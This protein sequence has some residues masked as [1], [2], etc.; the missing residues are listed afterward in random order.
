MKVL[1]IRGKNLASLE[2]EFEIDFRN[3]P[4][5]SAGIFAITG[6]TGAGK[7]TLLDALCLA[8]YDMTP[9]MS[10]AREN[11]VLVSDVMDKSLSQ[12]DTRSIL[13]RGTVDGYAE[14]DFKALDGCEY[15][16]RWMV[17]RSRGQIAG[18]L[19]KVEMRLNNLTTG[20]E[21]GGTKTELLNQIV[22]L[23]GLSFEQFSRSVL[24]AQGDFA[25]F[26]KAKQSEKAEILEKLTGTE[27][28][29]YISA[30]IYEHWKQA[31]EE[32]EYVKQ[33]LQ[34]I[35]ILS[36]EELDKISN[37]KIELENRLYEK[38][39]IIEK[40]K[41]CLKWMDDKKKLEELLCQAKEQLLQ[42]EQ[43]YANAASRI[44]YWKQWELV[45]SI[46]EVYRQ[47]QNAVQ[48]LDVYKK[49]LLQVEEDREKVKILLQ[50]KQKDREKA[51]E[52]LSTY[53]KYVT[54]IQPQIEKAHHLD[55]YIQEQEKQIKDYVNR[56]QQVYTNLKRLETDLNDAVQKLNNTK[57]K[58]KEN[59]DWLFHYSAYESL[60]PRVDLVSDLTKLIHSA[61]AFKISNEKLLDENKKI[62]VNESE[63]LELLKKEA[64]HLQTLLP[65]EV[66]TL[67]QG[68]QEGEACPVCGSVHH[69]YAGM[70]HMQSLH[71]EQ[72]KK[73]KEQNAYSLNLLNDSI[74][75]HTLE[76]SR[77]QVLI[78]TY[79][80]QI[81]ENKQKLS[82][83]V[84][85]LPDWEK[86]LE[87]GKLGKYI[88]EFVR[89]WNEHKLRENELTESE[90]LLQTKID[91]FHAEIEN[92]KAEE[93]NILSSYNEMSEQLQSRK[94]DRLTLFEG[95]QIAEVVNE[96]NHKQQQLEQ[97]ARR[98]QEE[99]QSYT[100]Q[101]NSYIGKKEQLEKEYMRY[102]TILS[103]ASQE[104]S[105]WLDLH[106]EIKDKDFLRE[107]F[108]KD[109]K[110]QEQEKSYLD[111]LKERLSIC[112]TV[113]KERIKNLDEHESSDPFF[114]G[115]VSKDSVVKNIEELQVQTE[116]L[117]RRRLEIL[118][119]LKKHQDGL[120]QV[121][122]FQKNLKDKEKKYVAWSKLNDLFGSQTGNK[123]KEIA[124]GY[125]LDILVLYANK[126]LEELSRRYLLQRIPDTLALQIID[127]DML[128][129]I[130]TVHSLSGGESF[131]V[132]LA[133]A[134]GLASLSSNRMNVESLFIDEGFGSLDVE[135]LRVAMETLEH[136]QSQGRKIGVI[137]HISE[138]TE[139]IS[140]QICVLK[141]SNG[142]S[143]IEIK[144]R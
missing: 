93:Q 130:R 87:E 18:S 56:K 32:Y 31:R 59:S 92:K 37:E 102:E 134:L 120:D 71:E 33:Q 70:T 21:F 84:S 78:D 55:A 1:A 6:H 137:S 106:K 51:D 100:S 16:S 8:L 83:L 25:T 117:N 86:W 128:G 27:I 99:E 85:I 89:Q 110:W 112:Q 141:E 101:I 113:Y 116:E 41:A 23:I 68:L 14:V 20:D 19:Q 65:T 129:E 24:L 139:R 111:N 30:S 107:L 54:S 38:S 2:K 29:S 77:L 143:R 121:L 49:Q 43:E 79:N 118:L 26:L 132:S 115:K 94:K 131:L 58:S 35:D 144:T 138:L 127:Q 88:V 52:D 98:F 66:I 17:R 3:E 13:R 126:H 67:R 62:L 60:I 45:Q 96:H 28:Y 122:K 15:R 119:L 125:T 34:N 11:N 7:T 10:K 36:N 5:R 48:L 103:E 53:K 105:Q 90:H 114:E 69:P 61:M 22:K 4:L 124:Q 91:S 63:R 40:Q 136:L 104:L 108:D 82:S 50:T 9:R 80:Q 123:F 133:L 95:R 76:I 57:Q 39:Q 142:R 74:N 64:E 109:I 42:T 97:I 44:S 46:K 12:N 72:L 73:A 47:E 75:K 140:T 81:L 135:T